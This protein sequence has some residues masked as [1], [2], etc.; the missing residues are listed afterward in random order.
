MLLAMAPRIQENQHKTIHYSFHHFIFKITSKERTMK[1]PNCNS[2]EINSNMK[3]TIRIHDQNSTEQEDRRHIFKWNWHNKQCQRLYSC[4]S[5][6]K[7][8]IVLLVAACCTCCLPDAAWKRLACPNSNCLFNLIQIKL[9]QPVLNPYW[10]HYFQDLHYDIFAT[11]YCIFVYP[12]K[13]SGC[14]VVS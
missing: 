7:N 1:N 5:Q 10:C 4:L 12:Q 3:R 13:N 8:F 2:K 9:Q 14:C 6:P 11:I